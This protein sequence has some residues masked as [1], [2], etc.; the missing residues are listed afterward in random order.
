MDIKLSKWIE[1]IDK[2]I[3]SDAMPII[4]RT[5]ISIKKQTLELIEKQG[6]AFDMMGDKIVKD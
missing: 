1:N 6:Y 3:N 4:I 5:L 2:E